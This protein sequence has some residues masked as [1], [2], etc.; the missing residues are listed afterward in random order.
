MD[1]LHL[2]CHLPVPGG[3]ARDARVPAVVRSRGAVPPNTVDMN[4]K[5]NECTYR[6]ELQ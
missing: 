2:G 1:V 4:V 6:F 3:H 5:K